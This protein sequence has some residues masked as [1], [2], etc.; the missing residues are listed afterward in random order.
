MK[1][2]VNILLFWIIPVFASTQEV[3]YNPQNADSCY[4]KGIEE[5]HNNNYQTAK[6]LFEKSISINDSIQRPEPFLSSNAISWIAHILYL[7]G[8]REEATEM[9]FDYCFLPIDQRQTHESDSLRNLASKCSDLNQSLLYS[10]YARSIEIST[11]GRSHYYIANSDQEIASIFMQLEQ[12]DSAKHYQ[13][14]AIE[15]FENCMKNEYTDVYIITLLEYIRTSVHLSDMIAYEK[16]VP[17]CKVAT[18]GLHGDTSINYAYTLYEIARANDYFNDFVDCI[19]NAKESVSTYS[20]HL[21]SYNIEMRLVL[22]YQLLGNAYGYI[23]NYQEAKYYLQKAYDITEKNKTIADAILFDIAYYQGKIGEYDSA[24]ITYKKLINLLEEYYLNNDNNKYLKNSQSILISSYLDIAEIFYNTRDF[25]STFK[26][27]STGL[28]LSEKYDFPDKKLEALQTLSLCYFH[29]QLYDKAIELQEYINIHST[30]MT[31]IYNLMW[32]YYAKGNKEKLYEYAKEYYSYEKKN[33]LFTFSRIYGE[34]RLDYLTNGEF[35]RFNNPTRFAWL[36]N[37]DD[38]IC[39][40]AYD[41]ELFRKGVLQTADIEFSRIIEE[42]DEQTKNNYQHLQQIRERLNH[43]IRSQERNKLLNEE[44]QLEGMLLKQIPGWAENI[45]QLQLSWQ[46]ISE[47]LKENELAVEFAK[48]EAGENSKMIALLIKR[49]WSTPKC[50]VLNNYQ[51]NDIR[52]KKPDDSVFRDSSLSG[53]IWM[54]IITTAQLRDHETIYFAADG[55]FRIFPI[56]YLC[57]PSNQD[58]SIADRFNI[59]RLSSTR[60]VCNQKNDNDLLSIT[61]Y[62]NLL[63]DISEKNKI[64]NSQKYKPSLYCAVDNRRSSFMNDSVRTGCKYLYWTKAEID[65]IEYYAS[66]F[67]PHLIITKYELDQGTEESFK[68]LSY[69][70]PSIIHLATHAFYYNDE[71]SQSEGVLLSGCNTTCSDSLTVEDGI[72]CSTEIELLNLRNTKMVVLSGCNTGLGKFW[73]D[74]IGGLQRAF[75]KAGVSTIVMSLWEV[76]DIATSYFMQNFYKL[77]FISKSKRDA[78][79][80]AQQLTRKKFED[81]YYWAAFIML[82]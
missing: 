5:F 25:D 77:L 70:S 43:P 82:D 21:P 20:L 3:S 75:K 34:N 29:N 18:L 28:S 81:P 49:D 30:N 9:S 23:N 68:N 14:E 12:W 58:L 15:I 71:L 38:S 48:C 41:C 53:A 55:D 39:S 54:D 7:E 79:V 26:Y 66:K 61:L 2:I 78:F 47:S 1:K 59:I 22:C 13:E 36:Y 65:S 37:N 51:C 16:T 11:L 42:C 6:E 40:L 80:Q 50:V 33:I 10:K 56:E 17:K 27:A 31:N 45:K 8:K 44:K 32:S 4:L 76:S 57:D 63:Y 64:A 73:V 74:G 24:L 46:D 69:N 62:G 60:N 35:D 67:L 19:S 72:L 52:I